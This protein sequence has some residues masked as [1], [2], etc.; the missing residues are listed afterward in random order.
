LRVRLKV[1]SARQHGQVKAFSENVTGNKYSGVSPLDK[2]EDFFA[3]MV[4]GFGLD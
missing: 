3:F 1:N 2:I 4:F